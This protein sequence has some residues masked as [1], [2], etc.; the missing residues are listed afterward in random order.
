MKTSIVSQGLAKHY[1]VKQVST[2]PPEELMKLQV[3]ANEALNRAKVAKAFID[4]AITLKYNESLSQLR[5]TSGKETGVVRLEDNGVCVVG[6]RSKRV[7]WDQKALA[8]IA[9]KIQISGGDPSEFIDVSYKVPERKY[10]AWP[11]HLKES[12]T[13]ARRFNFGR[14]AI[15]LSD[16]REVV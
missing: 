14:Q 1:S 3:E 13:H 4:D 12:F 11:S 10:T 7:T 9:Q 16:A 2:F 8:D 15:S 6:D 5:E